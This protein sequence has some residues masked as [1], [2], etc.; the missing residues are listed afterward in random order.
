MSTH[1]QTDGNNCTKSPRQTPISPRGYADDGIDWDEE[2]KKM[3]LWAENRLRELK[4]MSNDSLLARC[5]EKTGIHYNFLDPFYMQE[6]Y[7]RSL[8]DELLM[9]DAKILATK[10]FL[11][12]LRARCSAISMYYKN[13]EEFCK[14][15]DVQIRKI[16]LQF[17]SDC[18]EATSLKMASG[19]YKNRCKGFST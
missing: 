3:V 15:E 12:L 10:A 4:E 17:L 7:I 5:N 2:E 13:E 14:Q 11:H 18:D 1:E 16:L 9:R 19:M 8:A 6:L